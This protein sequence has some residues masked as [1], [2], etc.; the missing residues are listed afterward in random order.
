MPITPLLRTI[1]LIRRFWVSRFGGAFLSVYL[2]TPLLRR[3]P[4]EVSDSHFL[5]GE[6]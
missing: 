6:T 3:P 5:S 1:R 2:F 4:S